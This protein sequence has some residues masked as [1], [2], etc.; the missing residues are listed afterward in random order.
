VAHNVVRA[1]V[2]MNNG[3]NYYAED[4]SNLISQGGGNTSIRMFFTGNNKTI[5]IITFA[6]F[7]VKHF[8]F[9]APTQYSPNSEYAKFMKDL[10]RWTQ[11]GTNAHDDA[12]DSLAM[13]AQLYQDL[14]GNSVKFLDRKKLRI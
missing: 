5:K 1:D 11:R 9:K 4:L 14:T 13:L 3:G 6:D 7:V 8:V 12:P 10:F 2:E